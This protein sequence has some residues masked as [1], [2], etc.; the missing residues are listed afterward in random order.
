M[1]RSRQREE[2][3]RLVSEATGIVAGQG[4]HRELTSEEHSWLD[5]AGE[6]VPALRGTIRDMLFINATHRWRG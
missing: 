1:R 4:I 5:R 6:V 3:E 2:L